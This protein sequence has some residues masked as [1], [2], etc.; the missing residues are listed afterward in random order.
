MLIRRDAFAKVGPLATEWR[1]GEFIEWYARAEEAGL[2]HLMLPEVLLHR[3]V[4]DG[5][6]TR[7]DRRAGID[8]ARILH[9][10][11]ARRTRLRSPQGMTGDRPS[12]T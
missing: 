6:L 10:V 12:G 11:A 3:R 1:V 8:Y 2:S 9:A 4:H 7:R 5:N